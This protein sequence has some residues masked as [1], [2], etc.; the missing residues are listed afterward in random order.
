MVILWGLLDVEGFEHFA[1][2]RGH[3]TVLIGRFNIWDE[4]QFIFEVMKDI[5]MNDKH[6]NGH[7]EN[8]VVQYV[9]SVG[10]CSPKMSWILGR[11]SLMQKRR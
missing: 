2:N 9:M 11:C 1:V 3:C 7:L 8:L 10:I 5:L 4:F 6:H